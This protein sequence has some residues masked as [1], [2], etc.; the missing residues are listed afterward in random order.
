[1]ARIGVVGAASVE[2]MG[3][4]PGSHEAKFNTSTPA[5][6]A[7]IW[8]GLSVLIIVALLLSL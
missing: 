3:N 5:G 6:W 2:S 7:M 1:M 4:L 8:W